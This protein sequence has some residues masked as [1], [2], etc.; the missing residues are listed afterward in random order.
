[1][2]KRHIPLLALPLLSI[3]ACL[4]MSDQES[5]DGTSS[6]ASVATLDP[7]GLAGS[8]QPS[9]VI[10]GRI[11]ETFGSKFCVGA[12]TIAF[13]DPVL[14]TTGGRILQIGSVAGG[15]H[16]A[17]NADPTRCVAVKNASTSV[18]VRACT[19]D[20]ATWIP[21][22]GP[23]GIS[24]LFLNKLGGYLSGPNSEGK[25]N[26]VARGANGWLQQFI[27]VSLSPNFLP[28]GN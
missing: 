6:Q 26:V 8:P 10:T 15:V 13:Q 28:C 5:A 23:D 3:A 19:V 14:E 1:M 11:C 16:L 9:A 7:G 25:F 27:V 24:C 2:M 17:F 21:Q 22:L 12:P 20:S 18:E 4:D